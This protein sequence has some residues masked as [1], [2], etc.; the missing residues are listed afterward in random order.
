MTIS[1]FR[2]MRLDGNGG[3]HYIELEEACLYLKQ[4]IGLL[5]EL[6]GAGSSLLA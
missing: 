5:L 1:A 3:G 6:S 2:I 4:K